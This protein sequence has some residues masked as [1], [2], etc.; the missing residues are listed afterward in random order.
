LRQ[1]PF[2]EGKNPIKLKVFNGAQG[3]FD[4]EHQAFASMSFFVPKEDSQQAKPK[5]KKP[6]RPNLSLV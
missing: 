3:E 1:G 2:E 5:P 6:T 4:F